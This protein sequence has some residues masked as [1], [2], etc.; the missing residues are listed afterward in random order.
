MTQL[1]RRR[2]IA[3]VVGGTL[4]ASLGAALT[5]ALATSGPAGGAVPARAAAAA[6]AIPRPAHDP[7]YRYRG[8]TPLRDLAPGTPLRTR[9]VTVG[10]GTQGTPLPARQILYR[11]TDARGRAVATVTAVL[12]PVT[13]T[14]A[15]RMVG[16]LSFYDALSS[17]CDPSFTLRGGDPGKPNQQLTDVEQG[18][19]TGLRAAG[20]IVTVPDFENERLDYV[21]GTESGKSALDGV[22]A[23]LRAL[24]LSTSSTPVG[25]MGYSGGSIAADW[26]SELAPRYAPKLKLVGVAEGGLPVDLAHNLRYVDGSAVWSDVMPAA[27]IGIARSYALDLDHYLSAYG[28][29]IAHTEAH[30]CIGDFNG[31]WPHLTIHRLMKPRYRDLL[32]V[33]VF[34][35]LLNKLIMGSAPGHPRE[36]LMV[37]AG[38]NDGTGDGVMVAADEEALAYE[39]CHQGVPVEFHELQKVDHTTAGGLFMPLAITFLSARFAGAP[40]TDTC[41]SVP[42]GNSLAPIPKRR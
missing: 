35:R 42:R 14:V 22:K 1:S 21:S 34:R 13:G 38:K 30:Q 7:F 37:V 3:A 12:E 2:T 9:Q 8:A 20:Y 10:L 33:P 25:L 17:K 19:V 32:H 6:T 29:R 11:T 23:T 26:A 40:P 18:V 15:P 36:P 28:R 41:A 4:A 31:A 39:Y 27:M 5:T 24:H 16:Y